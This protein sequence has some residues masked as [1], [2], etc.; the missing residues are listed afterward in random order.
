MGL[1]AGRVSP[2]YR[3]EDR[4]EMAR[5]L[6]RAEP[7]PQPLERIKER[8]L[9][10]LLVTH[11]QDEYASLVEETLAGAAVRRGQAPAGSHAEAQRRGALTIPR[12]IRRRTLTGSGHSR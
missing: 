1:K 7:E 6:D 2:P 3:T 12:E 4:I 11:R 9:M 8:V 5:V 10:D